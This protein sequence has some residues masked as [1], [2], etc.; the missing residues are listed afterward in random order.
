MVL[1]R[2][3][4]LVGRK[5]LLIHDYNQS[6]G[7]IDVN[8]KSVYHMSVNRS[9]TKYWKKLFFNFIDICLVNAY[10]LYSLNTD[11]PVD[12]REFHIQ[13][14]ESLVAAANQQDPQP[15]PGPAGDVGDHSLEKLPRKCERKCIVCSKGRTRFWCPGCNQGVHREC[16]HKLKHFW[17]PTWGTEG[18]NRALIQSKEPTCIGIFVNSFF[19]HKSVA[20]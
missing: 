20:Y 16:Y 18:G 3:E 11:R 6:M 15:V 17:R 10:I 5:P 19:V 13:L 12:R 7:G 14:V 1:F 9:T 2:V 8:D 4:G